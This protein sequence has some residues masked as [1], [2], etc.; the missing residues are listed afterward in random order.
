MEERRRTNLEAERIINEAKRQAQV[1]SDRADIVAKKLAESDKDIALMAQSV[2]FI[3][4]E[5]KDIKELLKVDY[6]T[7]AEFLPVKVIVYT[8]T[9]VAGIG[10]IGAL[11]KLI[12]K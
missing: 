1:I 8:I 9:S 5:V 11:M 4:D 7:R 6:V 12:L 2:E 10:A 3:K